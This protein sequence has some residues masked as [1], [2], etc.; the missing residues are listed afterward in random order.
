LGLKHEN[1][2]QNHYRREYRKVLNVL[3]E[4]GRR[5]ESHRTE[6]EA[7]KRMFYKN[8]QLNTTYKRSGLFNNRFVRVKLERVEDGLY[9]AVPH[10]ITRKLERNYFVYRLF[11]I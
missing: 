7:I 6:V 10:E 2:L 3:I 4:Y 8:I 9:Y 5:D 1:A 11:P